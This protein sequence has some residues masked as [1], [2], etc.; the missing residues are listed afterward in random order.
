MGVSN[1][2]PAVNYITAWFLNAILFL[3]S[4]LAIAFKSLKKVTK[5][6]PENFK[7]LSF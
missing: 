6:S 4:K 1:K 7:S 3:A 5:K 2:F